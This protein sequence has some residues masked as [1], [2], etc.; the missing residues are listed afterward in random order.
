MKNSYTRKSS[1]SFIVKSSE[2]EKAVMCLACGWEGGKKK[3]AQNPGIRDV[4]ERGSDSK[5]EGRNFVSC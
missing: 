2:T 4:L 5:R 3:C 1:S